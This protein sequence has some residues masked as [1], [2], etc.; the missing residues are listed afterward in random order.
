MARLGDETLG[1]KEWMDEEAHLLDR[2]IDTLQHK[3]HQ[4]GVNLSCETTSLGQ[5]EDRVLDLNNQMKSFQKRAKTLSIKLNSLK[6][7]FHPSH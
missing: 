2:E 6:K 7:K 1:L 3:Y 5:L 4:F